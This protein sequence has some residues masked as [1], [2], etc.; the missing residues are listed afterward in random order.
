MCLNLNDHQI[1]IACYLLG[2]LYM[3]LMLTTNPKPVIPTQKIKKS[4]QN[5]ILNHK[6]LENKGTKENYKKNQL[7]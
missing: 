2:K 4:K 7:I 3:N 6:E 1:N 5:T